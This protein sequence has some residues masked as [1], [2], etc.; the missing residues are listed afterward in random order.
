MT[1]ARNTAWRSHAALWQA[2]A[3]EHP[4]SIRALVNLAAVALER[5]N[6]AA[7]RQ[8]AERAIEVFPEQWRA[9]RLAGIARQRLGDAPGAR[10]CLERAVDLGAVGDEATLLALTELL[11]AA[12]KFDRALEFVAAG[13]AARGSG[14]YRG[15]LR[16]IELLDANGQRS[17]ARSA[18]GALLQDAPAWSPPRLKAAEF[19]LADGNATEALQRAQEALQRAP[20]MTESLMV[21]VDALLATQRIREARQVLRRASTD[22]QLPAEARTAAA[23]RLQTLPMP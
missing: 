3:R 10:Q 17:A 19:A 8:W 5:D 14:W 4:R 6:P 2:V 16:R 7:A 23:E 18:L 20:F 1:A 22:A 11:H 12:G 15:R 13:I 9:W 21:Y